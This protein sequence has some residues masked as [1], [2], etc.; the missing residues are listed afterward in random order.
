V[1]KI[2]ILRTRVLLSSGVSLSETH[3]SCVSVDVCGVVAA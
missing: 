2:L 1:S 3:C